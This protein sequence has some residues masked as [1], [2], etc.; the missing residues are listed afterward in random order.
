MKRCILVL[1]SPR[2]GSSCLT[3]CLKM[4]GVFLG[5]TEAQV[6]DKYN[7]KGYYENA[8]ILSFNEKVL[9]SVQSGIFDQ[10]L[11]DGNQEKKSMEYKDELQQI[12]VS[13]FGESDL[14][15]IK[16]M[17]I[18]TL[19]ALYESVLQELGYDINIVEIKRNAHA[20]ARSMSRMI[21]EV[22]FEQGLLVHEKFHDKVKELSSPKTFVALEEFIGS[23]VVELNRIC[24]ELKISPA[25][26]EE[27]EQFVDASLL[28]CGGSG[29]EQSKLSLLAK[30]IK[31]KACTLFKV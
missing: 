2:S 28:H 30:K 5:E 20:S 3:A 8:K 29:K 21:N 19:F 26:K 9:D 10:K 18:I 6:K 7:P 15:A 22:S 25:P 11:L 1:S 31:K 12:I 27:V 23:P 14:I 4:S 17:R 16:D 13:E 24:D